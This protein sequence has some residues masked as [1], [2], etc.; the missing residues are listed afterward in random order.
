[1]ENTLN[2]TTG[3]PLK[4]MVRFALPLMFGNI[5]QQLYT[6]VDTAIVGRGVGMTALAALGAVDW[7]NWLLLGI[8]AGVT[9]GYS[10]RIS[11]KFGQQDYEGLK[12]TVGGAVVLSVWVALGCTVLAQLCLPTALTLLRVPQV[13]R[14]QAVL[15]SRIIM[16]GFPVV[17][18]YNL[19]ASCLRAVGDS[20]T[21]L[22]AMIVASITNI[23]LDCVAVFVLGW[24][25]AGAAA[26]TVLSQLLSGIICAIKIARTS[27]LRFDLSHLRSGKAVH[28]DLIQI[29]SPIAA[30]NVIIAVGG[31]CIQ[32][33]V[34][35]FEMS[36]IAGFTATN[37]LYGLLEIAALSYGYAVTTYVGQNYGAMRWD[38]IRSGMRSAVVLSICTA[39]G[40]A[41][42]MLLFGRQ[43]TMLFISRDTPE[44]AAAAGETA[45]QYLCTMSVAL[46][47]LYLLYAYLSALQGI[48]NTIAPMLSGFL[49]L[50]C[51][52]GLSLFVG[53]IGFRFGIFIAEVSAWIAA[54]IFLGISYYRSIHRLSMK[55]DTL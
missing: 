8:A 45:Y 10:V 41:T 9:Q 38:R 35:G 29:G 17:F 55:E 32:S 36:F 46:P 30:K 28:K 19:C 25:I 42:C 44:L 12:Q 53:A 40:I 22:Y 54:A 24:G 39:L 34:N 37:K 21:P 48:G 33:I 23:V 50:A 43:I 26:A 6:V 15:Y 14:P 47:A 51:R 20:R 2:M 27:V 52:V 7:L 4:L 3:S 1:M 13:L 31:M 49:E 18:F 11:Q 5:F 16:G